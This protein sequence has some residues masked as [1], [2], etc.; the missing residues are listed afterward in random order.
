MKFLTANRH[1]SVAFVLGT[2]APPPVATADSGVT[3]PATRSTATPEAPATVLV[4]GRQLVAVRDAVRRRVL[5][6]DVADDDV[7]PADH[8]VISAEHDNLDVA[9]DRWRDRAEVAKRIGPW[10]VVDGGPVPPSGDVH[11]YTS[12]GPYWW[13]DPARP[14]GLPYQRRD[15]EVNPEYETGDTAARNAMTRAVTDLVH[16]SYFLDDHDAGR[17]AAMVLRTWFLDDATRMKPHLRYGQAIPGRVEG[18]HIGI[19]D[20]TGFVR[21]CEAAEMMVGHPAWTDAD[22][23]GLR[24]WFAEYLEWLTTSPTGIREGETHNNH[25]TWYDVQVARFA[26]FSG[27]PDRAREVLRDVG[28]RRIDPQIAADGS[29][30]L[31]TERTLGITYSVM[32]LNGLI[33]LAEMADDLD[34]DLW[35]YRGSDG[36]GL[37]DALRYLEP[38]IAEQSAWPFTQ[39]RPFRFDRGRALYRRV[40][41][42]YDRH[43]FRS[44]SDAYRDPTGNLLSPSP[45]ADRSLQH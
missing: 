4:D 12:V 6:V 17:R 26:L 18:R 22:D 41:G 44:L 19:I 20:T 35:S 2:L 28:P 7:P 21:I 8:D 14:G 37:E 27:Q 23:A 34:V 39:I 3:V 24:H 40:A 1:L 15:G 9:I 13:P 10:S 38:F 25:A 30:P 45:R 36:A 16:A 32:N 5:K 11:D 43:T 42:V 31:E 29:M 33:A